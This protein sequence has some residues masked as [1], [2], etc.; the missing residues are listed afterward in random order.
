MIA[1]LSKQEERG[2]NHK[3]QLN[4]FFDVLEERFLDINPYCRCRVIQ[5]YVK[6]CELEQKF[7]KR[8]QRAAELA[9]RSLEDKSSNVR[10]NAIKLLGTLIKTH[11]FSV[12]HGGELNY[13][14]WK[15]RL[16]AVEAQL[17][18]LK[19]PA[20]ASAVVEKTVDEGL[21]DEATQMEVDRP[22]GTMTDEQKIAAV[23]KAQEEAATS[24][25]INKLSL[26]KRYYVEALKFIEVLHSATTIICQLLGSKNKSEVIEAMDYFKI[27]DAYKIEQNKLGIR[28]MLRLIWTKGNSDE[29]KGV[30]N[31]LPPTTLRGT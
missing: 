13:T 11:P 9:A 15:S 25:A 4:A 3:S 8:R 7:P 20:E 22:E 27:G 2:E 16:E 10:R 17:N 14:D 31:H 1:D 5:V 18:A 12:M 19:P 23:R 24:E 28:R 30:Q 26:T 29:G 6:I 21:L